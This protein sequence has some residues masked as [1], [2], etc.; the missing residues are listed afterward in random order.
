MLTR[1]FEAP[2]DLVWRAHTDP[3]LLTEWWG[4]RGFTNPVCELDLRPGGA[5]RIVQKAPD[6]SEHPFKGVFREVLPPER[7]VQ[8]FIYD[9][10]PWSDHEALVTISLDEQ[11][12]RT[13]LTS[14][15]DFASRKDRDGF[16]AS[17]AEE[18]AS[19]S[20]DRLDELLAS[21]RE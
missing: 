1:E 7:L 11:A 2:R 19:E 6:G 20:L 5:W 13:R 3:K 18:G 15:T 10:P 17:G 9:V 8:T 4:P 16:L 21:M 12:G 14:I